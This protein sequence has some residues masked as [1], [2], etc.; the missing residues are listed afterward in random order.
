MHRDLLSVLL[1][2][3]VQRGTARSASR[4]GC[5]LKRAMLIGLSD[6]IVGKSQVDCALPIPG[7]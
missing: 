6:E 3:Q 2:I 4:N 7:S 1:L 5:A